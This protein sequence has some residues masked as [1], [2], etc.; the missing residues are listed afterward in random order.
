VALWNETCGAA[1]LPRCEKLTEAR[2][3]HM[4][5]RWGNGLGEL[6]GWKRFF[7]YILESDFLTGQ[8]PT[9][10]GR[11]PFRASLDWVVRPENYAKIYEGRY[12]AD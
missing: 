12:H 7:E 8:T 3:G 5:A 11:P 6:P 9:I 10:K 4:R 2:K 1:G